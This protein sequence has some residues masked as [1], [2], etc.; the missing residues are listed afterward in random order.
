[1]AVGNVQYLAD[2]LSSLLDGHKLERLELHLAVDAR[3]RPACE[4]VLNL[5]EIFDGLAVEPLRGDVHM[6]CINQRRVEAALRNR[7]IAPTL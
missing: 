4:H 1:M 5:F 7:M 3:D 2:D 6:L